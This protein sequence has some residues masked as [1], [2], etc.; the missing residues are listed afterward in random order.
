MD[1]LQPVDEGWLYS[2]ARSFLR[3]SVECSV[4]GVWWTLIDPLEHLAPFLLFWNDS[5][6][7]D[8]PMC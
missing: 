6:V 1:S 8:G 4:A 5:F 7:L 2:F 3:P